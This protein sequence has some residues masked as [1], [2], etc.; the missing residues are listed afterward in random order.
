MELFESSITFI[1][2]L[3][4]PGI[5]GRANVYVTVAL[6]ARYVAACADR[7]TYDHTVDPFLRK[8]ATFAF[9]DT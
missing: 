6:I 8:R 2:G 3:K 1:V 9:A 7:R 5:A 4:H